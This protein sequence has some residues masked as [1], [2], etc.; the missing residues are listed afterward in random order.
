MSN[1]YVVG[2]VDTGGGGGGIFTQ[3]T[4]KVSNSTVA[5]NSVVL[6]IGGGIVN[7]GTLTVSNSTVANNSTDSIFG[8][9][10]IVN[11]GML[12]INNSTVTN[13]SAT[14]GGGGGIAQFLG[15]VNL[16]SSIVAKNS[17][18][19][20]DV[21]GAFT[22]LGHNLIGNTSGNSGSDI[23]Q[24]DLINVDPLFEL[25]AMGNPWLKDN[26]GP[27]VGTEPNQRLIP[28]I[29]L[30][31]GSPAIDH[32]RNTAPPLLTD[33]RGLGFARTYDD[34]A[35]GNGT[36]DGTDIG[37]FEV[38]L[39]CKLMAYAFTQATGASVAPGDRHWQS[40]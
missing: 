21:S 34:S 28:T 1:S 18:A 26:G 13:N 17:G 9:G 36:G 25:D 4:A 15:S 19:S 38:Q 39:P 29:A 11:S 32:G 40:L 5:Y 27:R 2:N 8:G 31:P 14:A 24:G 10:G 30:L 22:S 35:V 6:N 37:A 16:Q 12:T 3:G 33:Q 20:P 7:Q 23:S